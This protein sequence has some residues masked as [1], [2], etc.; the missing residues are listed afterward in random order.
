MNEFSNRQITPD[1]WLL[2][3]GFFVFH[4]LPLKSSATFLAPS[5]FL[6]IPKIS[7]LISYI[8]MTGNPVNICCTLHIPPTHLYRYFQKQPEQY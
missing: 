6:A 4:R 5:T 3:P 1:S 8:R 7:D 2:T